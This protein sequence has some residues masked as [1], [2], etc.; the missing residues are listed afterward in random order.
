M[1]ITIK[2]AI[3]N[4]MII[5]D[6]QISQ[7]NEKEIQEIY[8]EFVHAKGDKYVEKKDGKKHGYGIFYWFDGSKYEGYY[9]NGLREG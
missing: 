4:L 9:K 2:N 1:I 3:G 6:I 8:E 5:Y 7:L